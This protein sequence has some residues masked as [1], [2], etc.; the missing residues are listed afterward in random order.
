MNSIIIRLEEWHKTYYSFMPCDFPPNKY[1]TQCESWR[2]STVLTGLG[3]IVQAKTDLLQTRI[4][5][6]WQIYPHRHRLSTAIASAW[7]IA[8]GSRDL[9]RLSARRSPAYNQPRPA[10]KILRSI[11]AA[12]ART[13]FFA[14]VRRSRHLWG[15]F[16]TTQ[17]WPIN[18][19]IITGRCSSLATVPATVD[20]LPRLFSEQGGG[21]EGRR[22]WR[23][24]YKG[25]RGNGGDDAPLGLICSDWKPL[26]LHDKVNQAPVI[27]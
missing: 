26:R 5:L 4:Y 17:H 9:I 24:A 14:T 22:W 21:R 19:G 8:T 12:A 11:S 13:I 25:L 16:H 3:R 23:D 15:D 6:W 27:S 2:R 18:H 10:D 1:L 20:P 7:H